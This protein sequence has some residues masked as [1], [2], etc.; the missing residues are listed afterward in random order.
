MPS[1]AKLGI[2]GTIGFLIGVALVLWVQPSRPGGV[3]ILVVIPI[4]VGVTIGGI[5]SKLFG[6]T[7]KAGED[8]RPNKP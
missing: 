4:A 5:L 8:D 6:T 2:G 7:G 3:A 1:F